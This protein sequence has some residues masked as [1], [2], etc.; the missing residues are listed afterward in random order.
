MKVMEITPNNVGSGFFASSPLDFEL[1]AGKRYLLGVGLV[2]S[3][4]YLYYDA[5]P[6]SPG[7]SF[8]G[9]LG[10]GLGGYSPSYQFEPFDKLYQLRITSELP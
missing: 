10:G 8:G 5:P 6:W 1:E 9:A 7:L 2:V 3:D 4:G